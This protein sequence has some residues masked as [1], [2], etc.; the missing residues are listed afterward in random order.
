MARVR[1]TARITS[2]GEE[3]EAIETSPISEVMRQS[4]LVITVGAFEEGAPAAEAE[5]ADIEEGKKR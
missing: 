2:D 5:Q 3:A 1:S 4:G